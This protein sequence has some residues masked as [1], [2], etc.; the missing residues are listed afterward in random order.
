[1]TSEG[2]PREHA[3]RPDME[4]QRSPADSDNHLAMVP[5]S[6]R[7]LLTVVAFDVDAG[8]VAVAE[9]LQGQVEDAE[10]RGGDGAAKV[11]TT[12]V[13]GSVTVI[14]LSGSLIEGRIPATSHRVSRRDW[15]CPVW[16]HIDHA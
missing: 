12:P 8:A 6:R 2:E 1:M 16:A 4:R 14:A 13:A 3:L 10:G 9:G 7:E 5:V 11:R 15:K